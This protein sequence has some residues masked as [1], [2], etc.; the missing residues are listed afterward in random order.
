MHSFTP[1]KECMRARAT[2]R[3]QCHAS[4]SSAA[5]DVIACMRVRPS[6]PPVADRGRE[7]RVTA[8]VPYILRS[9]E[10][11]HIAQ[12][13]RRW[14]YQLSL[15]LMFP[16]LLLRTT[17]QGANGCDAR[18]AYGCGLTQSV[19]R[20]RNR[21]RGGEEGEPTGLSGGR[22]CSSS[23]VRDIEH[24][25]FLANSEGR[26]ELPGHATTT[27]LTTPPPSAAARPTVSLR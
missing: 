12:R 4:N 18:T 11:S 21:K 23:G 17:P 16:L 7:D 2:S 15:L 27:T 20:R 14:F 26:M 3:R 8:R 6:L 22:G 9:T 19:K 24:E 5:A 1:F 25:S 13:R 10:S